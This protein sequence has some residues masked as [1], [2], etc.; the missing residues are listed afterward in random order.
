MSRGEGNTS[1]RAHSTRTAP[2]CHT[3]PRSKTGAA[4]TRTLT[5]HSDCCDPVSVPPVLCHK[6]RIVGEQQQT[7]LA[8]I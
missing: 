5:L 8:L 1:K 2:A 4:Q 3:S 7:H 6:G